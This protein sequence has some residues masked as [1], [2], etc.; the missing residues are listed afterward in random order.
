MFPN[1]HSAPAQF[2]RGSSEVRFE[3]PDFAESGA[4]FTLIE[5]LLGREQQ[6]IL[7]PGFAQAGAI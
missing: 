2:Q 5:E 6:V 4:L 3:K 1:E 7:V